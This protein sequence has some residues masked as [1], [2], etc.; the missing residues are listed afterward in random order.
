MNFKGHVTQ[1]QL[2]EED[3]KYLAASQFQEWKNFLI[4]R[5]FRGEL[6]IQEKSLMKIVEATRQDEQDIE[7]VQEARD[8]L[9]EEEKAKI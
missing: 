7:N 4:N 9:T 2:C 8:R 6:E 5:Y 1:K 3:L